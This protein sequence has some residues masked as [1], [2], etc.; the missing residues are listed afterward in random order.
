MRNEVLLAVFGMFA[1]GVADLLRRR[2]LVTG[3]S[4]I[5]YMA[6]ES[7]FIALFSFAALILLEGKPVLSKGIITFSPVSGFLIFVGIL[8][9]LMALS[10]GEAN[11]FVPITRLGFVVTFLLATFVFG[12]SL[13]VSKA[14][15]VILAAA[16]VILLSLNL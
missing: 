6:I 16:A 8:A 3:G 13:T 2:G 10:T 4:P 7:G 11:R 5:T 12:E 1:V 14:I 15:G 9:L